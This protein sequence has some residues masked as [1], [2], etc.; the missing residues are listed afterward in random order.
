M[1]RLGAAR[2]FEAGTLTGAGAFDSVVGTELSVTSRDTLQ[3]AR[4]VRTTWAVGTSYGAF[5]SATFTTNGVGTLYGSLYL[6]LSAIPSAEQR[7]VLARNSTTTVMQIAIT[8]AGALRLY[9]GVT[10]IGTSLNATLSSGVTYRLGWRYTAGTGANGI[11][12]LYLATGEAAFGAALLSTATGAMTLAVTELRVGMTTS[13]AL[14]ATLDH[15]VLDNAVMPTPAVLR[16]LYLSPSGNDANTAA[17]AQSPATPWLTL[18]ASLPKLLPG[19]ELRLAAGVYDGAAIA[20]GSLAAGTDENRISVV[21]DSA[22]GTWLAGANAHMRLTGVHNW[23][24]RQLN[25]DGAGYTG[26]QVDLLILR[27]DRFLLERSL[28]RN[29]PT[30]MQP[31]PGNPGYPY[32]TFKALLSIDGSAGLTGGVTAGVSSGWTVRNCWMHNNEGI[33]WGAPWPN[34]DGQNQDHCVYMTDAANGL[35]EGC[36]F[37]QT[38]NGRGIKIGLS[39]DGSPTKMPIGNTVR[40]NTFVRCAGP[41]AV[42]LSYSASDTAISDNVFVGPTNDDQLPTASTGSGLA[43][44]VYTSN[45]TASGTNNTVT[46]NTMWLSDATNPFISTGYAGLTQSGNT[47]ADPVLDNRFTPRAAALYAAGAYTRGHLR[48]LPSASAWPGPAALL[49]R[50]TARFRR[51]RRR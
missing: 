12:E 16:V 13:V 45:L 50:T 15:I 47:Y 33:N 43:P 46:A 4:A 51:L 31:D 41:G 17:Q 18:A 1:A 44:F 10:L 24:F 49:F 37:S 34:G 11:V 29:T 28:L 32:R 22:G 42:S 35:V 30:P 39:A 27:G 3:G 25:I 14:S 21:G 48:G 2:T 19:D 9:S 8:A 20:M 23:T 26:S 40:G 36:V 6:N 7:L 38:P 5:G